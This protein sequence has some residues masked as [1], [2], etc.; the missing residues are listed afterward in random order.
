[1]LMVF[2]ALKAPTFRNP[3]NLLAVTQQMS[4]LGIMA[5][6]MTIVIIT[7]GIDLSLG[8]IA[9]LTTIIIGSTY[10]ATNNIVLSIIF[11]LVVAMLCGALNGLIIARIG[12][13][14][15]LVTLGGQTLYKG[16]A[17]VISKGNAISKFPE[18]Y[19]FIGQGYVG[20]IP[21]QTIIFIILAITISIIL[22]KTPWGQ[23]V[24]YMGNNPVATKCS[25]VR[26]GKVLFLVYMIAGLLAG[27]SG[28]VISSRVAT[29]R[30]DLGAVYVLQCV[31]AAVLGGTNIAG[32]SGKI[33]GT[34]LGV[35]VFAVLGNGFNHMRVSPFMQTLLMGVALILVLLINNY[36][37]I[38]E[39]VSVFVKF[40]MVKNA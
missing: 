8:S 16:I 3:A 32:G 18:S 4:E 11:G 21:F 2:M 6:G 13:P 40:R 25:G 30:A 10:A 27:I 12:V 19:Y 9:G 14:A 20:P 29:A 39:K 31:A 35:S 33:I 26:T 7:S 38:K 28:W 5:I 24:Y 17:L 22:N 37:I 34:V 23:S 36:P 1:M 15:L